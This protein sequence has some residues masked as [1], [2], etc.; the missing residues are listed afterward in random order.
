MR[1]RPNDPFPEQASH[2]EFDNVDKPLT[3]RQ[4][5]GWPLG[6]GEIPFSAPLKLELVINHFFLIVFS[7]VTF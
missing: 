5:E 2:L 1:L 3:P 4:T 7:L 6:Y